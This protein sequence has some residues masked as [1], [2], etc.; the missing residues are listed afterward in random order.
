MGQIRIMTPNA[1][2]ESIEWDKDDSSSVD[3]A[4][5]KFE[6]LKG[7][8][9]KLF[10]AVSETVQRKGEEAKDFDPDAEGYIAVPAMA[11]G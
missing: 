6:E 2:D 4:K 9:Y 3:K 1:G 8:G 5:T 10:K 7:K 11:G